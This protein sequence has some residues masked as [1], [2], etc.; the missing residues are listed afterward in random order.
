MEREKRGCKENKKAVERM[1][2]KKI[3]RNQGKGRAIGK[4]YNLDWARKRNE[5]RSRVKD[6]ERK[7][8]DG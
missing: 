2:K 6:E 1:E 7:S 8:K 3:K 5:T 4:E